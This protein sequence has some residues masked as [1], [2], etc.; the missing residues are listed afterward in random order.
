MRLSAFRS[1][2]LLSSIISGILL[3]LAWPA[4]GFAPLLFVGFIPLLWAEAQIAALPGSLA[5]GT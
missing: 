4:A 5:L 2:I 1:P 3:S